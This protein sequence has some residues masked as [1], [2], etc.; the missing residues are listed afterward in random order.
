MRGL[1]AIAC[2][3]L[4]S[5]VFASEQLSKTEETF[6][7]SYEAEKKAAQVRFVSSKIA[8]LRND[9]IIRKL[10]SEP[11]SFLRDCSLTFALVS[12][13]DDLALEAVE[14]SRLNSSLFMAATKMTAEKTNFESKVFSTSDNLETLALVL[15]KLEA[16]EKKV[17]PLFSRF[18]EMMDVTTEAS[19][20]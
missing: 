11:V 12:S 8:W 18:N 15:E 5:S 17:L 7:E 14:S 10:S 20:R 2:V 6:L 16:C 3:C 9:F 1:F 13:D 4:S 19:S